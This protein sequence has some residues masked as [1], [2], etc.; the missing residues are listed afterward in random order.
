[1][2]PSARPNAGGELGF[3]ALYG[4]YFS[5]SRPYYTEDSD[6]TQANGEAWVWDWKSG[7]LQNVSKNEILVPVL[8]DLFL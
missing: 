4:T 1:M 5:F 3:L 6:D 2:A 8:T 7:A